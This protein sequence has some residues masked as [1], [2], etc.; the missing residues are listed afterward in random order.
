MYGENYQWILLG[1]YDIKS[2]FRGNFNNQEINCT[3]EEILIAMN[4]TLQTRVVQKSF[5]YDLKL[6]SDEK[7]EY[8]SETSD[9]NFNRKFHR[10]SN[11][12]DD[13]YE[14]IIYSYINEFHQRFKSS[15]IMHKTN[16]LN[17]YFHGYAFDLILR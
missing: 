16:C 14:K 1:S 3:R 4:G 7:F 8:E 13:H 15:N 9:K 2:L 5:E 12:F 17:Q 11:N 10:R 6:N